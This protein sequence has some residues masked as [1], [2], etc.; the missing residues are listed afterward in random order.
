MNKKILLLVLTIVSII[1]TVGVSKLITDINEE[2]NANHVPSNKFV[3]KII[4]DIKSLSNQPNN[5]FSNNMHKEINYEIDEFHTQNKLGEGTTQNNLVKNRLKKDLYTA[6][7]EK[8]IVQAFYVFD[9][10]NYKKHDL[11]FIKS[12]ISNLRKTDFLETGSETDNKFSEIINILDKYDEVSS[13]IISCKYF[14]YTNTSLNGEYP[15]S[16]SKDKIDKSK[17]YLNNIINDKILIYINRCESLREG[18]DEIPQTLLNAH[19]RYLDKKVDE[20]SGMY[21]MYNS[22]KDYYQSLYT[23]ILN[24]INLSNNTIYQN[25]NPQSETNRLKNKW[26]SDD[27]KAI[28]YFKP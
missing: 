12:E 24:E 15:F 8:F 28:E 25:L 14:S 22:Y 4:T 3:E 11:D 19:I 18:L 7:T 21:S 27:K 2:N 26:Q 5:I 23:P 16:E 10:L 9:H 13:F 17:R 6:Y 1:I 20:W